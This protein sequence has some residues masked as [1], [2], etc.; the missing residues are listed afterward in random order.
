MKHI[1]NS[2]IIFLFGIVPLFAQSLELP[3]LSV[4]AEITQQIGLSEIAINYSRPGVK[5]RKIWGGLVPYNNGI[6][7]PWRAGANENT[8][9]KISDDAEING[10]AIKA[11]IYGFHII[12]SESEWI[13][14]FNNH[15]KSWGSFFYDESFDV[16]RVK[17]LP[18]K[19]E[20]TEWLEYGFENITPSSVSVYMKW[21]KLKIN[22]EIAFNEKEIVLKN[23][24][25]QLLS[26]P[27]FGWEGPME[28]AVFCLDNDFNYTEALKWIDISIN[29]N[30]VFQNKII[31]A[32]LLSKI[33]EVKKSDELKSNAFNNS[34][35]NELNVFGYELLNKNK[36]D[37]A[38]KIFKMN[39]N[40]HKK[41]WNCYDSYADAL[42]RAGKNEEANNNY[43]K[44]LELAPENQK[45]RIRKEME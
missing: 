23:I 26:L 24:R 34:S 3:R 40:R 9:I 28:A 44:A 38:L 20:F 39:I 32:E 13:L 15:N 25:E 4:K 30:P 10:K 17:V 16:L 5:G 12:P 43:K 2:L 42:N 8:I 37:E 27:G 7:F 19:N 1:L 31:K 36:I 6:P 14:I 45:D 41:S 33:G 22:F 11:G 35:E 18:S 21:E 29:R